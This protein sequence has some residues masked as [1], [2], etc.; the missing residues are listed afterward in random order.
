LP[1]GLKVD[2]LSMVS[3]FTGG[4]GPKREYLYWELHEPHFMQALRSGDW[5][6]V[7][8]SLSSP[9]ELYNLRTDPGER[10]DLAAQQPELVKKLTA[11]MDSARTDS[12]DW[13]RKD[14]AQKGT[15]KGKKKK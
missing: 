3:L 14:K 11:M 7:R 5:K 1:E 15:K 13:P 9:V 8:P 12:P 2:G 4:P 10:N 6:L